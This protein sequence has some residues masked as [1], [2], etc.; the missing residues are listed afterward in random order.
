MGTHDGLLSY[1]VGQRKGIA[2]SGLGDGPWY[3]VKTDR[4]ANAVV[5]GRREDLARDR[6]R[7]SR[8]NV[9]RP[10]RFAGGSCRGLAVCRYR[11]RPIEAIA[12]IDGDA[13]SV[14]LLE[15]V[16]VL[17]PGQLLVLYDAEHQEVLASGIIEG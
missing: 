12:T 3:V 15:P 6:V 5:I 9:L 16:P 17:S 7:C 1:T 2:T 11:S 10:D 13:M 4:A 8:A 14:S